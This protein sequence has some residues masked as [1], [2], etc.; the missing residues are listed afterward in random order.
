VLKEQG[1]LERLGGWF[2]TMAKLR[3]TKV[4]VDHDLWPYFA[5]R[6]GL[7]VFGFLEPKPGMSPTTAHLTTLAERMR[8]AEVRVV[9]A[10]SYF[11]PQHAAVLERAVGAV[12]V[13]MAH[14]AGARPGTDDY[15]A[16]VDYN[17]KTLAAALAGKPA[18]K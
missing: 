3:G 18:G 5:E 13:P 10:S 4:V 7:Q 15:I 8:A 6:F 16:F 17:V 1:D 2:G 14:Q 12:V 11:P 9:L